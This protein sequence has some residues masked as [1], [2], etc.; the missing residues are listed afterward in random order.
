[1]NS[2]ERGGGRREDPRGLSG[3]WWRQEGIIMLY[4]WSSSSL[5]AQHLCIN[6]FI[7]FMLSLVS[8]QSPLPPFILFPG[9]KSKSMFYFDPNRDNWIIPGWS[10]VSS[11]WGRTILR[12]NIKNFNK[13]YHNSYVLQTLSSSRV[14]S[15]K[16]VQFYHF[17]PFLSIKTFH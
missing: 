2:V 16:S 8:P 11:S 17:F 3:N 5:P 15:K 6:Y 9:S 1:M 10:F 13:N 4:Y 12:D 14:I 7:L